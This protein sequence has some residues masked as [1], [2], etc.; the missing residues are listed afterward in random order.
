[1][2]LLLPFVVVAAVWGGVLAANGR[3][4]DPA[5]AET[6]P[7]ESPYRTDAQGDVNLP[8]YQLQPGQF[9]P[10]G[11]AHYIGGELNSLDHIN[12]RGSIRLD[13]T[14][15][16]SRPNWD[17][18]L[19]FELL[20]Y[21]SLRYHGAPAELRD[22]P[23]GVHLNGMF[24]YKEMTNKAPRP[25]YV[26]PNR[27]GDFTR[28]FLLEDDFSYNQRLQ[29]AWRIDEVNLADHKLTVTG[30]S[31]A[32]GEPDEKPTRLDLLPGTRIWQGRQLGRLSDLAA[33][34]VV[35]LNLTWATIYGPGRCLDIW[36]DEESRQVAAEQQLAIHRQYQKEHGLAA[37]IDEVDNP[38]S[39][40]KATLFGGFDPTLLETFVPKESL[41]S[42]V[43][44]ETLRTY[45]QVNDR[46][47]GS[48][49][50]RTEVPLAPGSSGVQI[51]F[52]P[53]V[54]LEGFRPGRIVRLFPGDWP[55]ISLP[56]EEQL[57]PQHD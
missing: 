40:I 50:E 23:L 47:R 26:Y 14:D 5:P 29:R 28:A 43:S 34:Q 10:A 57:Y 11:S 27:D 52:Q 56:K 16:Q 1:M 31:T 41:T 35:Q 20:P 19:E 32:G 38:Q 13:R 21:G 37:W 55:V 18:S 30:V 54:L 2:R 9:P 3:A 4:A 44:H 17:R 45:D 22:I 25:G 15:A 39:I 42:V 48:M 46:I 7:E 49:L 12:R 33:G 36:V 24:Y 8:W 51:T 53:S 6:A